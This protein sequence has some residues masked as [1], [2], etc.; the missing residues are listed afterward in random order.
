[1]AGH[2]VP[3]AD[4]VKAA[5]GSASSPDAKAAAQ[6]FLADPSAP[7]GFSLGTTKAKAKTTKKK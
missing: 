7:K 5:Q 1:L 6:A 4:A 2:F 3:E